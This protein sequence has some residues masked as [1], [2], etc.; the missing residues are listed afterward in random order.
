MNRK[1][2]QKYQGY[3]VQFMS[4]LHGMQYDR[5][6]TF[7]QESL[8][9]V[10]PDE[11]IRWLCVKSF[12]VEYPEAEDRP[13]RCRSS[14]LEVF[15]K[16]LSWYMPNRI[17]PWDCISNRGNP[18]KSKEVNKLIKDVKRME[19]RK[20]GKPPS[21]KRVL[22]QAEFRAILDYFFKKNNF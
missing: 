19:V 5:D 12:G 15:K 10:T 17:Q 1:Q 2:N 14:S 4:Y 13:T 6:A 3:L 22:T 7:D 18:T 20:Q 21:T 16:A 11:I 9:I 8:Q